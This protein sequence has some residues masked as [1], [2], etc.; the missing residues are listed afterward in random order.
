MALTKRYVRADAAGGGDGTTDTNSGANGAFTWAEMIADLNTPH[1]AYKYLVKT[2]T[3]AQGAT[4]TTLTGDGTTT[5]PIVIE[6]FNST[7]GDLYLGRSSGGALNTTNFPEITFSTGNFDASGAQFLR[8]ACLKFSC[9]GNAGT[10][11]DLTAR[12]MI[13]NCDVSAGGTTK[14]ISLGSSDAEAINCDVTTAA[15]GGTY[16]I[17]TLS[18]DDMVFGCRITCPNGNGITCRSTPVIANNTIFDCGGNGIGTDNI[19]SRPTIISN[20]IANCSGDGIN[21]ITASTGFHTIVGNHITG[22]G[23]YGINFNTSTCVKLLGFNRFRDNTSGNVSG[24]GEWEEGTSQANVTSDDTDADDFTDA[25]TDDYS[26]VAGAPATSKN[27]GYLIDIGANGTPVVTGGG[28]TV[29]LLH[30]KMG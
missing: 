25:T 10:L 3:Y 30:G 16:G 13:I 27:V 8:V 12:G 18:D 23:G 22:N 26:L 24:G 28:G 7:E 15:S 4:A 20:T 14:G 2:G 9:T 17:R 11:V 1:A 21:I 5:S 29:N 6:G 19:A